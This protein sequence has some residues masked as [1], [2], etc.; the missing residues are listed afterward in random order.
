MGP[1]LGRVGALDGSSCIA[2]RGEDL[3]RRIFAQGKVGILARSKRAELENTS[4]T[5][6]KEVPTLGEFWPQFIKGHCEGNCHKPSSVE[7]RES[8]YRIWITPR[9]PTKGLDAI[10]S[11]E[12]VEL[13]AYFV[14][15]SARSANNV[16]TALSACLKFAGPEAVAMLTLRP[17]AALPPDVPLEE[18]PPARDFHVLR[19]NAGLDAAGRHEVLEGLRLITGFERSD[20]FAI[21]L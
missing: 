4:A 8:A 17:A 20:R 10:G 16:L 14:K 5:I 21:D 11:Q 12:R 2:R 18:P 13:K 9:F 1:I 3:E 7:R 6:I 15:S 19:G